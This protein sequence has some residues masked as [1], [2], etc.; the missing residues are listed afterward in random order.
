MN[1]TVHPLR[2]D[3][4]TM[5]DDLTHIH[6][7]ARA[8]RTGPDALLALT[9]TNVLAATEPTVTTDIGVGGRGSLNFIA[10]LV[11]PSGA[12]KGVAETTATEQI[13]VY[14]HNGIPVATPTLPFGSGEGIASAYRPRGTAEDEPHMRTR[15]VFSASEIDQVAALSSRTGSTLTST[16]RQAWSGEGL[17]SSNASAENSNDVPRHTYRFA[18]VLGVQPKR[19]GSLLGE[20]A[21][22]GGTP[23]RILWARVGDPH[24]PRRKPADPGPL[25]VCLPRLDAGIS[26]IINPEIT[27]DYDERQWERL[28]VGLDGDDLDGHGRMVQL[29]V[30]AALALMEGRTVVGVDDWDIAEVIVGRSTATR[31]EVQRIL[32]ADRKVDVLR[33]AEERADVSLHTGDHLHEKS[34]GQA[35]GHIVNYLKKYGTGTARDLNMAVRHNLRK[36]YHLPALTSLLR[37]EV[38]TVTSGHDGGDIYT[39]TRH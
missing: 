35:R 11:G 18:A 25:Q 7:L 32:D 5:R 24:A 6:Q 29:K 34:L 33:R 31:T 37:E 38:V 20:Q 12:G 21:R 16:L 17:G 36:E 23:Q 39:L 19:A 26:L 15:V 8:R 28:Q 13:V 27:A 14:G 10:S 4:F 9:I 22:A 30:A 1:A 3:V 2:P